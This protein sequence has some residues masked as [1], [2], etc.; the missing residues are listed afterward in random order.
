MEEERRIISPIVSTEWLDS[1][2]S[3]PKLVVMDIRSAE[4]YQ[5]GH[6]PRAINVPFPLW[7]T[8]KDE[9]LYEMPEEIYLTE[10]IGTAGIK[11]DSIVIVVNKAEHPY[12]LADAARVADVLLH[13]GIENVAILNGGQNK[14]LKESRPLSKDIERTRPV[15]YKAEKGKELF[16]SKGYVLDRLGKSIV[17]DNRDP[18]AYFGTKT[19][20]TARRAG[21][22]P[23]ARC[24]P[25]PWIW[26][27]DGTYK[28]TNELRMMVSGV[29]GE[30]KTQEIIV[31][32]GVGGYASAWWFVLTQL[33]GYQNVKLYGGSAQEWTRDPAMPMTALRWD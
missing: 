25:A 18:D 33:L 27:E 24:L 28:D 22:I 29:A 3:N 5:T 20:P 10:M 30:D 14:W 8:T 1:N 19:E 12:P 16:A 2:L 7:I 11:K 32:C 6:I 13:D 4:E 21:H 15:E 9:M 17:L 23:G 26:R 31:Y